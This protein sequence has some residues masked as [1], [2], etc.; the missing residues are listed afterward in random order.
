M[1]SPV[2]PSLAATVVACRTPVTRV[3]ATTLAEDL[4]YGADA[5]LLVAERVTPVEWCRPYARR[6]QRG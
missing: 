4:G 2:A 5:R 6:K 3:P 1:R